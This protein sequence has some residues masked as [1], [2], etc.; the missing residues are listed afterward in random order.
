MTPY[1]CVFNPSRSN[2]TRPPKVGAML[3]S[4]SSSGQYF[5]TGR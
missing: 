2:N 4:V 1:N 3:V 5:M